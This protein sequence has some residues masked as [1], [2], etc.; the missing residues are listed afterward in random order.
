MN[1]FQQNNNK[2]I[3]IDANDALKEVWQHKNS[4]APVI[5]GTEVVDRQQTTWRQKEA[6]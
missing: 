5:S 4:W 1:T 3:F 2:N 6:K